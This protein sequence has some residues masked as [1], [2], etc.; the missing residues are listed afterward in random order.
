MRQLIIILVCL[1]LTSPSFAG[2]IL[3]F[4]P[5]YSLLLSP[6]LSAIED[7]PESKCRIEIASMRIYRDSFA[8]KGY[9]KHTN[10]PV[11]T[12]S[13]SIKGLTNP[14]FTELPEVI[15]ELL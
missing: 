4:G 6:D 13:F 3:K 1:F 12:A 10:I 9:I 14:E 11:E 5:G 8:W 2:T 15:D 7:I